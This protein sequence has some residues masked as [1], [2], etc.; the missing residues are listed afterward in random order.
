MRIDFSILLLNVIERLLDGSQAGSISLVKLPE[1]P[2]RILHV[3]K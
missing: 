2:L 1:L 3:L